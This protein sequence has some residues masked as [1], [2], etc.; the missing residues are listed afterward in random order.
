MHTIS[1]IVPVYNVEKYLRRC[2]DSILSQ[3]GADAE[4]IC[5]NDGSTDAS[6][7]ILAEYAAEHPDLRILTQP[8]RGLGAA[9]NAGLDAAEGEYVIFVDSDDF[10]EPGYFAAAV[11]KLEND[12]ADLV[13]FNPIIYDHRTGQTHPYRSMID[14]YRFSCAGGFPVEEHP[15]LLSFNGCWDKV[16]RRSLL[17]DNNI[18]FP[19]PRIYEDVTFGIFAQV[20]ARKICVHKEGFYNY[21]KNTGSSITDREINNKQFRG[22]FLQNL[23][24]VT[25]FLRGRG[26]SGAVWSG[27]M[28]YALRDGMFHLCY[29]RPRAEF[30]RF[31][32]QLRALFSEEVV[33]TALVWGS[34]KIDWFAD[35]LLRGDVR[36]C[37]RG[38]V[39]ALNAPLGI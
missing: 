12:G 28:L 21:R 38:I 34:E 2:L 27:V 30:V 37:K 3:E 20:C 24:E 7:A 32:G 6:P 5:V 33:R 25:A 17:T 23:R 9:R 26:C 8:N 19:C 18:R 10:L 13:M 36:A 15:L 39:R 4:I 31:F 14:F 1:V 11:Q 35:V 29:S 16:C 22:D